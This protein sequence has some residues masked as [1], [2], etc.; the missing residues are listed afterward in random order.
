MESC[1]FII[2]NTDG[3]MLIAH[4]TND[5][6]GAGIWTFPKGH[7][8]YG[9]N[10]IECALREVYEETNLDLNK[11]KGNKSFLCKTENVNRTVVYFL[12]KSQEDLT[13]LNIKCNSLVDCDYDDNDIHIPIYENDDFKWVDIYESLDYLSDR[14]GRVVIEQFLES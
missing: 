6:S 5:F 1:G 11:I 8:E 9:E 10:Q 13:K 7:I 4:P 12:F 3:K 2:I 14:E